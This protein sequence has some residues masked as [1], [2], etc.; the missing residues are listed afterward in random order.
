M[1]A[2][3]FQGNGILTYQSAPLPVLQTDTD[4]RVQVEAA[5]IC[6]SDLHILSVPPGQRGEPGTIMG[7]EFVARVESIGRAVT[8]VKPGDRVVIEPNIACGLCPACR[9]GHQNLCENAAT[10]LPAAQSAKFWMLSPLIRR[11]G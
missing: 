10:S 1:K 8:S 6:G 11:I 2:A 5:S 3:I 4:V 7:H 9:S